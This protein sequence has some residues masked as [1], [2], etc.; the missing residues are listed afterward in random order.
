M[1]EMGQL[2]RALFLLAL[3]LY[4]IP[5]VF[6]LGESRR[7]LRLGAILTLGTA[8]VIAVVESVMWFVR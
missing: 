2:M 4:L 1:F 3:L 7:W 5:S 8:M 6:R